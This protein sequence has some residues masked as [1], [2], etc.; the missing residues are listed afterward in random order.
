MHFAVLVAL[1]ALAAPAVAAPVLELTAEV[2][3][4]RVVQEQ[5][6]LVRVELTNRSERPVQVVPPYVRPRVRDTGYA[7]TLQL[8]D[9]AGEWREPELTQ[10]GAYWVGQ[11]ASADAAPLIRKPW[12]I[13]PGVASMWYALNMVYSLHEPG[14]YHLKLVY[15]PK[16]EMLQVPG[17]A[18]VPLPDDLVCERLEADLG[19]IEILEPPEAEKAVAEYLRKHTAACAENP[20]AYP[21]MARDVVAEKWPGSAYRPHVE[22]WALRTMAE[23][24]AYQGLRTERWVADNRSR[25]EAFRAANPDFPL[26]H[27][28]DTF[29]AWYAFGAAHDAAYPPIAPPNTPTREQVLRVLEAARELRAVAAESGDYGLRAEVEASIGAFELTWP[30]HIEAALAGREPE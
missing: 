29:V 6:I 30:K 4:R 2:W 26:S 27:Q 11:W 1:V 10:M 9:A 22:F 14:R 25:L 5:P 20:L 7:L 23:G 19:W 12:A 16:P 15:D 3:T 8:L 18:A 17:I 28:L 21:G 13:G 24:G